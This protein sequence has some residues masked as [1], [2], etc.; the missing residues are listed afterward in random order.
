MGYF[1]EGTTLSGGSGGGGD[2]ANVSLSNLNSAGNGRFDAKANIGLDNLSSGGQMIIDSANGTISNCILE[3]PQNIK[4]SI[5]SNVITLAGG[6][7]L[8]HTGSTYATITTTAN[9]TYTIDSS[10]ADGNY[11]LCSNGAEIQEPLALTITDS[12]ASLPADGSTYTYFYNTTDK[13]IYKYA[14]GAWSATS[15]C[16]PFVE[17]TMSGGVASF[18]KD[19]KG[20]DMIF[21]GVGFIGHHAF[22]YPNNKVLRANGINSDGTLK[23]GNTVMNSLII[24][25]MTAGQAYTGYNRC[26][27]IMSTNEQGEGKF[28]WRA[29]KEVEDI[30]EVDT[31]LY[32]RTY[33]R[34]DNIICCGTGGGYQRNPYDVDGTPFVEY[35]YNGTTVTDFTIRQP[36]EG[37]RYLLTDEIKEEVATKQ[38]DVTTLTGYDATK[39]QTLKNVN[40]V[41]TWVDDE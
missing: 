8:T 18:A 31:R 34:K 33:V 32:F 4:A 36:Y 11:L 3:I 41:L 2:S 10:L 29:Y 6:S 26:L 37:A 40:G 24:V 28:N 7:I 23:S 30:S 17:I 1:F 25:E 39:T 35:S 15:Y 19:S 20:R 12:G 38:A 16:Y 21:N 9:Q 14:D 22:I 13:L 27:T 5:T